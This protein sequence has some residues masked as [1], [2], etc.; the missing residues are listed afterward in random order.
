MKREGLS[1][2]ALF[3]GIERKLLNQ[4]IVGGSSE[5]FTKKDLA[6]EEGDRG[7]KFGIVV[8]GLFRMTKDDPRGERVGILFLSTGDLTGDLAMAETE[9]RYVMT[10]ETLTSGLIFWIPRDTYLRS[11]LTSPIIMQRVQRATLARINWIAHCR[12]DQRL[13]LESRLAGF[14]LR[15]HERAKENAESVVLMLTRRDLADAVGARVESV[16][17]IMK[18][19][20]KRELVSTASKA[21]RVA[22]PGFLKEIYDGP[23]KPTRKSQKRPARR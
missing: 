7:D 17:R 18:A 6:F 19:W 13:T 14:L 4:L 22:Q 2:I 20:E 3:K 23:Q 12:A 8:S 5:A 16:I 15:A 10:C 9:P 11:W 21:I 1:N